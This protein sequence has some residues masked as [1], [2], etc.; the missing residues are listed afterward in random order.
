MSLAFAAILPGTRQPP[1][2][3]SH[4]LTELAKFS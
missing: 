1:P 4:D 2:A 3:A